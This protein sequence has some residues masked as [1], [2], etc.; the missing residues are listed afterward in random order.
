MM[1]SHDHARTLFDGDIYANTLGIEFISA[2]DD[3]V[4]LGLTVTANHCNVH[5]TLHGAVS[6]ALADVSFAIASNLAGPTAVAV[7]VHM[8]YS[9]AAR[10]GDQIIAT[11]TELRRG[12][13]LAT[14][15]SDITLGDKLLGSFTGTVLITG[16]TDAA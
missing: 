12:R 6:Y 15:R 4:V 11:C 14:Y 2:D 7:D 16:A 10:K 5:G 13:T 1:A 9:G 3:A 8:V